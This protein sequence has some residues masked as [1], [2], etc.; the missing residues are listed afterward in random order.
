[1]LNSESLD[2]RGDSPRFCQ[3][4]AS[5]GRSQTGLMYGFQAHLSWPLLWSRQQGVKVKGQTP[6]ATEYTSRRALLVA[7]HHA[8]KSPGITGQLGN[9]RPDT[10]GRI[11]PNVSPPLHRPINAMIIVCRGPWCQH[12][13]VWRL[14]ISQ[15]LPWY[16]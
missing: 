14:P 16:H 7:L 12:D 1:M 13:A 9:I 8:S 2:K 10:A 5:S 15:C 6:A 4:A 3:T 11:E